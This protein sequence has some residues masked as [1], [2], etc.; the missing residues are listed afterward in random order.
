VE[1]ESG[2]GLTGFLSR[3]GTRRPSGAPGDSAPEE[4]LS[5]PAIAHPT[6]ALRKFLATLSAHESPVLLDLG[7]VVGSNLN[8][9]GETLGCKVFIEDLY[10]DLERHLR[11]GT[12]AAFP[13]FLSKRLNVADQSVD[14]V[15]AW[16]LFDYLDVASAQAL[17]NELVRVM[18]VE[19]ALLGF[20]N[21]SAP[22]G[23][24]SDLHYTKYIVE[25]EAT[26]RHRE[27]PASRARQRVLQNRD[28]I[29]L[30]E[31]LRVSDSFL[32]QS[33]VRE[34]LFRKPAYL[35]GARPAE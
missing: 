11:A 31:G 23:E 2:R 6:K 10:A 13:P 19:G 35:A 28:V 8:F 4:R 32:L 33:N 18:R 14:G 3:L 34:L 5:A 25:D 17:A 20:F 12:I 1:D 16:D 22:R 27:Y 7:P 24:R 21:A 29:K 30:F 9:F 26:L 15:L